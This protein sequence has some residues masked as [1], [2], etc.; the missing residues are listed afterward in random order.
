[1]AG[2]AI[3]LEVALLPPQPLRP[4]AQPCLTGR[5]VGFQGRQK[6]LQVGQPTPLMMRLSRP[7]L[8]ASGLFRAVLQRTDALIQV[9]REQNRRL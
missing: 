7:A 3:L 5:H 9:L 8:L 4:K 6:V 2:V 1:M